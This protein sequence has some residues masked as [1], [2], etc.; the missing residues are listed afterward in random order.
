MR[1]CCGSKRVSSRKP[2]NTSSRP[3][4]EPEPDP[5]PEPEPDPEPEI[6]LNLLMDVMHVIE[7][8]NQDRI[9]DAGGLEKINKKRKKRRKMEKQLIMNA[10]KKM[11]PHHQGTRDMRPGTTAK[12]NFNRAFKS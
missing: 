2:K 6:D 3:E 7:Q 12:K 4:P 9:D 5:E 1:A 10:S 11:G 8:R